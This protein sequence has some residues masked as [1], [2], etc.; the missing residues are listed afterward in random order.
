M[1]CAMALV[2]TWRTPGMVP[3]AS[4]DVG[5][6]VGDG[7]AGDGSVKVGD[8]G[9]ATAAKRLARPVTAAT[10]VV[11]GCAVMAPPTVWMRTVADAA[12]ERSGITG[13]GLSVFLVRVSGRPK[14]HSAGLGSGAVTKRHSVRQTS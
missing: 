11:S 6:K 12:A 3:G 13:F 14:Q 1:C 8:G 7:G 10:K 4:G 2:S 9:E 5:V